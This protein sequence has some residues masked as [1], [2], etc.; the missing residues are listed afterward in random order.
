MATIL[1]P[2]KIG[3]MRAKLQKIIDDNEHVNIA[4]FARVSGLSDHTVKKFL[5]GGLVFDSTALKIKEGLKNMKRLYGV[6]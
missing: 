3:K 5:D 2:L 6:G 1:S 4:C